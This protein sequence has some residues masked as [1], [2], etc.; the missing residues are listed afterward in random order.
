MR[1]LDAITRA[2]RYSRETEQPYFVVFDPVLIEQEGGNRMHCFYPCPEPE[3]DGFFSGAQV[4]A[5]Y[6]AGRLQE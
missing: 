1:Q 3:L 5:C 2:R 4:V 6:A